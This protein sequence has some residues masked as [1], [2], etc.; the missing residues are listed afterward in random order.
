MSTTPIIG[1]LCLIFVVLIIVFSLKSKLKQVDAKIL[2]LY[3]TA[4]EPLALKAETLV[5]I[6]GLYVYPIR[7]IRSQTSLEKI[8]VSA[9]GVMYDR[10][11][12]LVDA[13]T[14]KHVTTT[15]YMN[16]ACLSQTII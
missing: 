14:L 16:M 3:K 13:E 6:V 1:V 5:P 7:G 8:Y 4:S 9:F 2:A 12:V 11:L 15:N 10:E